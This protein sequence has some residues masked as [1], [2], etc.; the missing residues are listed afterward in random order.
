MQVKWGVAR[1]DLVHEDL[2]QIEK[3]MMRIQLR[4]ERAGRV[5]VDLIVDHGA[6]LGVLNLP[7]ALIQFA[8]CERLAGAIAGAHPI[9]VLRKIAD[10]VERVPYRKLKVALGGAGGKCDPHFDEM[11]L[12]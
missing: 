10:L 1:V 11:L 8:D 2:R 9:D 5:E 7:A 6:G 12:G 3:G 4:P